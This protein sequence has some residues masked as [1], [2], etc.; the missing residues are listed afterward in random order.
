MTAVLTPVSN[1]SSS[2]ARTE[3]RSVQA[4]LL[5]PPSLFGPSLFPLGFAGGDDNLYR[6]VG[7]SPTNA[8]DPSGLVADPG[9]AIPKPVNGS[10]PGKQVIG[11]PGSAVQVPPNS[12]IVIGDGTR[13]EG[14]DTASFYDFWKHHGPANTPI[15]PGMT[16]WDDVAW[17][18]YKG[19]DGGLN[20]LVLDGH[21]NGVGISTHNWVTKGEDGGI[22]E[23]TLRD[24]PDA[25]EAIHD[26]LGPNGVV[27]ITSCSPALD[28][29]GMQNFANLV[30]HPVIGSTGPVGGATTDRQW[31]QF[32]PTKPYVRPTRCKD[33][34]SSK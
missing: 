34:S 3:R 26:K 9:T 2:V 16:N 5:P 23:K 33:K 24:D 10:N 20:A 21:G 27:I 15:A 32:N 11:G 8:S 19:P 22:N 30:G 4:Q 6:Y 17:E 12:L 1:K 25:I 18:L 28:A 13:D 14:K 7:N 31:Q 29:E